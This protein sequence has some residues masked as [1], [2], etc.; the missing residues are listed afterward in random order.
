[1][2]A[3][4]TH[5]PRFVHGYAL[6]TDLTTQNAGMCR[7]AYCTKDGREYFLKQFLS[8]KYPPM[9]GKLSQELVN[10]MRAQ[11][12][13]FYSERYRFYKK[14]YECRTGNIVVILDFFREGSF[15][16]IVTERVHG[17]YLTIEEIARMS[18]D[19]KRVLLR[20][21]LYSMAEVHDRHI[22]HADLKPDNIMV[23]TTAKNFCT[24]KLIDFESSF[25]ANEAPDEVEGDQVYFSPEAVLRNNEEE[26][27]VTEKADIFALGVLFHQ[28]WTGRVPEFDTEEYNYISEAVLDGAEVTLDPDIPPDVRVLLQQ[29]LRREPEQRPSARTLL[30][31]LQ[32]ERKPPEPKP[33]T[34]PGPVWTPPQTKPNPSGAIV[35]RSAGDDDL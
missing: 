28:Y 13:R 10:S 6:E 33:K 14:L 12:E 27:A 11:A 19:S 16:Y 17:P 2:A 24:A 9:D 31:E 8:P 3:G 34:E 26:V 15:Y 20:S 22:V 30:R 1:M 29:M 18:E 21:V 7:W 25:F 4:Y 23:K 5:A 32:Q 35:W